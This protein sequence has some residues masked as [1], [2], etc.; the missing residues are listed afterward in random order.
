MAAVGAPAEE[1]IL[2]ALDGSWR[3]QRVLR[4]LRLQDAL[5]FVDIE[6]PESHTYLT[7]NAR[8]VLLGLGVPA[9]DVPMVRGPSR[10]LTRGLATW[11]H[12]AKDST[13]SPLYGGIRYLSRLST[14]YECWAI[15]EGSLVEVVAEL[16]ITIDNPDLLAVTARHGIPLA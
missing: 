5:P 11:I 12:Q 7:A 10:K 6:S 2:P 13:G 1:L 4:T 15:F 8:S 14:N 3:A 9:L 16:R